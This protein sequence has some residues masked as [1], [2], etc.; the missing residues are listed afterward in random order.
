PRD[1][2]PRNSSHGPN[3]HAG[4]RVPEVMTPTPAPDNDLSALRAEAAHL[5]R[6]NQ[7]LLAT[8]AELRSQ[9]EQQQAHIHRLLRRT[10]GPR[11]AARRAP[12]PAAPGP[13]RPVA[14]ASSPPP[15]PSRAPGPRRPGEP[16]PT[17]PRRGGGDKAAGPVR[18]TCPKNRSW[19]R[20]P[21]GWRSS[22]RKC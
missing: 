12:P 18:P 6:M 9:V 19:P 4:W 2:G 5:R 11:R 13:A 8:V 7:E 3:P 20:S 22:D 17:P 21:T 14:P 16:P 1:N 10:F 15:P